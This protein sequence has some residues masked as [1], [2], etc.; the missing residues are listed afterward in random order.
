MEPLKMIK[1]I[2][3]IALMQGLALF[4]AP[5]MAMDEPM[6]E[7]PSCHKRTLSAMEEEETPRTISASKKRLRS[8]QSPELSPDLWHFI[9]QNNPQKLHGLL[10]SCKQFHDYFWSLR[11]SVRLCVG[12]SDN[13]LAFIAEVCPN[14]ITLELSHLFI[15]RPPM[16]LGDFG[17]EDPGKNLPLLTNLQTLI[18]NKMGKVT[19]QIIAQL[20]NLKCLDLSLDELHYDNQF[21]TY[22]IRSK[23]DF[24]ALT[25]LTELHLG[26][27][28]FE[29]NHVSQLTFLK[30]LDL[31]YNNRITDTR[32]QDMTNLTALNLG[33]NR[34]ITNAG[35]LPLTNLT[36]LKVGEGSRVD[37]KKL[38]NLTQL[39]RLIIHPLYNLRNCNLG[40]IADLL[41]KAIPNLHIEYRL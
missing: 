27:I 20:T 25:Q 11:S 7:A 31:G 22:D 40:G 9:Y 34:K 21:I 35:L 29:D 37:T 6:K 36:Q 32:I 38:T 17:K 16:F 10:L 41:T 14:L 33:K 3:F 18:L 26:I 13:T 19:G 1:K 4:I 23:I 5:T 12:G 39:Q 8:S 15:S 28:P 24:A 2:C 30:S